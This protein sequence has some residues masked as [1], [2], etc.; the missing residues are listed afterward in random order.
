MTTAPPPA[1]PADD[2]AGFNLGDF[3]S[4]RYLITPPLIQVIYL[5]GAVVITIIGLLLMLGARGDIGAGL[6][7]G[8][9]FILL[10]N[11]AWRVYMELV[12]LLFR[13]NSGIQQIDRNTRR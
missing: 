12:M 7:G 9:A 3:L 11:L 8:L 2:V 5:V 4:F 13:I 10:G 1:S 6:F